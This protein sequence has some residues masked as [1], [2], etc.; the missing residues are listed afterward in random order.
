MCVC[1]HTHICC[2]NLKFFH[3]KCSLFLEEEFSS[4]TKKRFPLYTGELQGL[5]FVLYL[6][7]L[8][9]SSSPS[10]AVVAC[11]AAF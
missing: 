3:V 7:C 2:Q 5:G 9:L 10:K 11:C 8:A 1:A 4:L 6:T